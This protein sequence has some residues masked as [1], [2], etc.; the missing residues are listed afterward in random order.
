M[1]KKKSD[2]KDSEE[3][4][5]LN[6]NEVSKDDDEHNSAIDKNGIHYDE[7]QDRDVKEYNDEDEDEGDEE[8][9][10]DDCGII[11]KDIS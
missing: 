11:F 1:W 10:S 9:Y 3:T 7:N 8:R 6:I 5:I 2:Y 4:Q